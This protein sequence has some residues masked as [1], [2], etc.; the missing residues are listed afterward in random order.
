MIRVNPESADAYRGLGEVRCSQE[1]WAE[2]AAAFEHSLRL[3]PGD[4]DVLYN[5]GI[6]Y[7]KLGPERLGDAERS[8]RAAVELRPKELEF[9]VALAELYR[10]SERWDQAIEAFQAASEL[11]PNLADLHAKMAEARVRLNRLPGLGLHSQDQSHRRAGEQGADG[12]R[13]PHPRGADSKQSRA[14]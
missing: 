10:Q 11:Q 14:A 1:R 13:D 12:T 2:A 9:R 7:L 4:P 3:K 8:Y 6:A 5:L